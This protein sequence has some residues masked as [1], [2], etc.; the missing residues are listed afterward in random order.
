MSHVWVRKVLDKFLTRKN[1]KSSVK[2]TYIGAVVTVGDWSH[3]Q[4]SPA[5][6]CWERTWKK[7]KQTDKNVKMV[8]ISQHV[9]H[10]PVL[11]WWLIP[12]FTADEHKVVLCYA[13]DIMGQVGPSRI[14]KHKIGKIWCSLSYM[15]CWGWGSKATHFLWNDHWYM[16]FFAG[17]IKSIWSES[18]DCSLANILVWE[19]QALMRCWKTSTNVSFAE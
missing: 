13:K 12:Q 2:N 16:G 7:A 10:L 3:Q 1:L 5:T 9:F 8:K 15:F 6:D 17:Q 14:S 19:Q 11:F 18:L 4:F